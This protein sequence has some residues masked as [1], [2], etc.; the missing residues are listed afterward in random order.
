[1]K[2]RPDWMDKMCVKTILMPIFCMLH[3]FVQIHL[4]YFIIKDTLSH[5][6]SFLIIVNLKIFKL[7]KF[8][9]MISCMTKVRM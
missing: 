8:S 1:M 7:S 9:T 3:D 6:Y 4:N 2:S 5:Y